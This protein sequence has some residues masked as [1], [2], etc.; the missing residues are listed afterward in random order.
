MQERNIVAIDLGN[1]FT[2]FKAGNGKQ[3]A[4]ASLVAPYAGSAGIG[5]DFGKPF[6]KTQD[7]KKY[8]V[9][10]D[11]REEGAITRSTDS[12][13]YSSNEIRVLFLR[14]LK[15]CEIKNPLIVT[16]LP[17]E[18]FAKSAK[19]FEG[20]LKK[21]AIEEGYQPDFIKVLPQWAGPWFDEELADESGQI[22]PLGYVT[23]GKIGI[24]DIGQGTTDIGQFNDGKV[25]DSRYGESKGV[26]DIH[27]VL[28]TQLRNPDR[29]NESLPKKDR[30]PKGFSLDK[31]STQF[32]MDTWLREGFIPWR[33][34]RLD[35]GPISRLAREEFAADLLPRCITQVWGTTDFLSGMIVAGGGA[36][37]LG[38]DIFKQY[39]NCPIF[40]AS[41]PEKSIVRGYYRFFRT[42]ILPKGDKAQ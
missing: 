1:G 22:L 25:S 13:F 38:H 8:L 3:G 15:L 37:V 2:S 32:T 20:N 31:Q 26:S 39:V 18:F 28:Y 33:G 16:G 12:S 4:F 10:D 34:S 42:Q 41:T 36:I 11:C 35:I 19:D 7:G 29:F 17:T 21:W 24:I 23:K 27:K 6:F 30:L 9:G 14:A 5:G 40:M